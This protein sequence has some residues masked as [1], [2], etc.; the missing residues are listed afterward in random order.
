MNMTDQMIYI[1]FMNV[2][3]FSRLTGLSEAKVR[4]MINS[5]RDPLPAY[6]D[7]TTWLIKTDEV[8]KFVDR[9]PNGTHIQRRNDD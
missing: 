3:Q 5:K 2:K 6:K 4:N 8:R 7:G 1:P 9:I